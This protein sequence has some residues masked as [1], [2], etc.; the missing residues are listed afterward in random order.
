MQTEI[1]GS[2]C[3]EE[4]FIL[5]LLGDPLALVGDPTFMRYLIPSR[6]LILPRIFL[7]VPFIVYPSKITGFII[8][9]R[10]ANISLCNEA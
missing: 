5:F 3:R 10:L 4:I 6:N 7:A 8:L 1:S 9:E 2:S